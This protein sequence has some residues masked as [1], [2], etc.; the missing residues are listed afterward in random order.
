MPGPKEESGQ[1]KAP[2]TGRSEGSE[3]S[4]GSE[5]RSTANGGRPERVPLELILD[6]SF[7]GGIGSVPMAELRS[8]RAQCSVWEV[9]LSYL[10]RLAQGRLDILHAELLRRRDPSTSSTDGQDGS[11]VDRLS[12]ILGERVSGP[13]PGRLAAVLSPDLD[14]PSLTSDLDAIVGPSLLGDLV[15]VA[16]NVLQSAAD[17]LARWESDVSAR[18]KVLHERIDALQGEIVRRYQRGEARVD[19]LLR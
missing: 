5:E 8:R 13:G 3:G 10:R 6:P 1:S 15:S 11:L 18:R 9:D 14:D 16:D 19:E 12:A 7:V 17:E 2:S 4:G